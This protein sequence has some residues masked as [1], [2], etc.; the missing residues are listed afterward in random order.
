MVTSQLLLG[1]G[2]V[3]GWSPFLESGLTWLRVLN[4]WGKKNR[5]S[6]GTRCYAGRDT[7]RFVLRLKCIAR[8]TT[9]DILIVFL[10]PSGHMYGEYSSPSIFGAFGGGSGWLENPDLRRETPWY[11]VT[12]RNHY[13]KIGI[14]VYLTVYTTTATTTTTTT[15]TVTTNTTTATTTTTNNN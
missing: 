15:T 6:I 3:L 7:C 10:C 12:Y 4:V 8:N 14:T 5:H 11:K 1:F 2:E 9:T 13:S